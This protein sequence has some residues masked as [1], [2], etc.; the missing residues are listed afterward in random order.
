MAQ[1][2]ATTKSGDP[3]KVKALAGSDYCGFH[4]PEKADAFQ[5]GRVKGGQAGKLATLDPTAI[6]PW[7]GVAGD[8]DVLKSVTSAEL[9]S[10]LCDTID[11]VRTGRIDPKVANAIGYLSG[12]I[13]KIQE[14]GALVERLEAIEEAIGMGG[15]R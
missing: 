1:C 12:A 6:K 10:L 4:D 11:D 7:R 15:N 3:C 8:V 9:V 13:V 5:A 2:K 14:F